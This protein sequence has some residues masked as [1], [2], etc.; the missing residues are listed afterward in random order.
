MATEDAP[1]DNNFVPATLFEKDGVPGE[2]MPGKIDE[3]TGRILVDSAAGSGTVTSVSVVTANGFAGTVA[4]ATS[5][6]AITLTTTVTGILSGNGTAVSAASTTGTGAV[7]LADTPTLVTPILGTPTSGTL[8]NTT[9]FPVANLAGAGAG[10]LTFLATPSSA[11]LASALT[12][13]TGTGLAVFNNS[14]TFVDDI[15]IGGAGV[16]TG[17]INLSGTT[18]GTVTIKTADV[19]GTWTLTLPADDGDSGQ[20]LTTNGLGVT[21]WASAGG[22][23]TTI[24][25]ANEATDATCFIGFFT[26]ATGDLGPKTNANLTFDSS[27]GVLTSASAVLT[28]ADING[29]TVDNAIIGG[30]TAAAITGTTITANTGF[31]PD[32][33][34]G[35]YLG[36][37]G[38]AFSDLFLASGGVINWNAG[39]VTLTHSAG[40]LT[41]N[42]GELRITSANVGTNADSV[43]TLSS[44]STLTN[45]TLTSPKIGTSILD[46]GGNELLLLTAT[47][48]AVN[49]ITLANAATGNNPTLT[50]SGTDANVGF[51]LQ[52]KGTGT[53]RLLGTA[54]QA[55]E[56]RLYEDT[57]DGTNYTAFKVGTQTAD[58]TYTLPTDDGDSGQVLST[59]GSG[60]LDWIAAGS[61]AQV[62]LLTPGGAALPN[63]NYA[64]FNKKVGTNWVENTL[65]FDQT[66][67]EAC[68][69]SVPIMP[70]FTPSS[71]TLTIYWTADSGSGTFTADVDTRSVANDEVWDATTTPSVA[72]DTATD[73]L[74]TTGDVHVFTVTLTTTGWAAEDMLQIKLSRDIS[75]TL[76]AD[77][78]VFKA[79]LKIS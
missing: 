10:V 28:T 5:T 7:V 47:A 21:T 69:W 3:V 46:T 27:T 15:T 35:A 30:S 48:S 8:T 32:A 65:D 34:D 2:V 29:G 61:S 50:A 13:E 73:T 11:N 38:T 42:A 45:K 71:A 16:A 24:T 74:I 60:V 51:D 26:A 58:I 39:N 4:T 49:E 64:A 14:P 33:D 59:N 57:S 67:S 62:E 55:A 75:D 70:G 77:A 17:T 36:Q 18:S 25:V 6:P 79:I 1:R 20:V 66:T 68:Y 12:D 78:R 19:A 37:S 22:V 44:T 23:P 41:Q 53:Y 40:I 76:N 43:P 9:G 52:A 56:L 31:M 54:D 63:T 72:N